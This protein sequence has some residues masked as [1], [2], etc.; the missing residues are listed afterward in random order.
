MQITTSSRLE[1][2]DRHVAV[3]VDVVAIAGFTGRDRTAVAA[4]LAELAELGVPTPASTPCFY[5]AAPTAL[6]QADIVTVVGADTSGEAECVIVELGGERY[7]TVGSDHTDRAAEA[8]DIPLSK[9]VCPK[10]IARRGWRW[11]D[12]ADHVAQLE[13]RSWILDDDGNEALYQDGLVAEFMDLDEIFTSIPIRR[14]P[15]ALAL[16]CGTLPAIGGIRPALGFRAELLDPVA[17]SAIGLKYQTHV[18]DHLDV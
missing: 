8:I 9:R 15:G 12:V 3:D 11:S 14:R 18:V 1:V 10:P 6:T 7:L 2:D 5:Q 4:H 17:G 16:F 13:L